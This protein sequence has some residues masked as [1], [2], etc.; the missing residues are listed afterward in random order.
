MKQ[1]NISQI[2]SK[3]E[4]IHQ[5]GISQCLQNLF[6]VLTSYDQISGVL[7]KIRGVKTNRGCN[8]QGR[9]H[10]EAGRLF[11]ADTPSLNA[12]E[13]DMIPLNVVRSYGL[14]ERYIGN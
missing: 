12:C 11:L 9:F 10:F 4:Y 7:K 6:R 14:C 1:R 5:D 8:I 2:Q 3:T 13:T